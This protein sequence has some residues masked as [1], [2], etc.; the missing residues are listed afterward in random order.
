M[1]RNYLA[2]LLVE[3]QMT[4]KELSILTG[5]RPNTIGDLCNGFAERASFENLSKICEALDC[6]ID[7]LLEF[8]PDQKK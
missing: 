7:Q 5:I 8:V 6:R 2:R 4:R 3:K 1:I